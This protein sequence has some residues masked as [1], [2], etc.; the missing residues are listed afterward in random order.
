M[1]AAVSALGGW[2]CEPAPSRQA[3]SVAV[4]LRQ[5]RGRCV[6]VRALDGERR[7]G[8]PPTTPPPPRALPVGTTDRRGWRAA[9]D[10]R[11]AMAMCAF[12]HLCRRP[13]R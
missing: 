5:P 13:M 7:R 2:Q 10:A 6:A 3:R 11:D 9:T 8:T 1:G 12:A 4:S